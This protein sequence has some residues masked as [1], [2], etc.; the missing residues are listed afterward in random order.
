MLIQKSICRRVLNPWRVQTMDVFWVSE[1][2]LNILNTRWVRTTPLP[3]KEKEIFEAILLGRGLNLVSWTVQGDMKRE[4]GVVKARLEELSLKRSCASWVWRL[5]RSSDFLGQENEPPQDNHGSTTETHRLQSQQSSVD[6]AVVR[7]TF[8]SQHRTA[9]F[10]RSAPK[11]YCIEC[12]AVLAFVKLSVCLSVTLGI[13]RADWSR[14]V[15][16]TT[17]NIVKGRW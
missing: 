6:L 7:V 8:Q 14:R 2:C 5:K 10:P 4:V 11:N 16:N 17:C 15:I 3:L 13:W 1:H 12:N 9:N